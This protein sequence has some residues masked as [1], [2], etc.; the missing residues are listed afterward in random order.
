MKIWKGQ[1]RFDRQSKG[2]GLDTQRSQGVPFYTENI[3]QLCKN[4]IVLSFFG[5]F[6]FP[7]IK[8]KLEKYD[9]KNSCDIYISK[10][11]VD[12]FFNQID[13]WLKVILFKNHQENFI[14]TGKFLL[15]DW[16][17]IY[18]FCL[19]AFVTQMTH[20]NR[21]YALQIQY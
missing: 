10:K 17:W 18:F 7:G 4:I 8:F 15:N 21:K 19:P 11:I 2:C 5:W 13:F 20:W 1:M 6:L 3:Y 14:I 9:N 12:L 16:N